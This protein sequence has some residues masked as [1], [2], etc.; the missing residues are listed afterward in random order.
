MLPLAALLGL[1]ER[2]GEGHGLGPLDPAL[3]RDLAAA[4]TGSPWSRLC[5]TVT[6]AYGIAIG[7][8]CA[9]PARKPR[10]E[11]ASTPSTGTSPALALPARVNLTIAAGRLAELAAKR[12][13]GTSAARP[14]EPGHSSA[15]A[16]RARRTATASGPLPCPTADSSPCT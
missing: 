10:T 11:M 2:P 3:C 12:P 6:D 13:P 1:A 14:R 4:A 5:V 8:G 7:H 15:P 16:T 9:K